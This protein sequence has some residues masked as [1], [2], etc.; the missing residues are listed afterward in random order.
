MELTQAGKPAALTAQEFKVLR[1]FIQNQD[2][3][4]S[5]EELLNEVWGIRVILQ[6]G[7]LIIIFSGCGKSLRR[8]RRVLSTSRPCTVRATSLYARCKSP[9]ARF[10][11]SRGSM[12]TKVPL[13]VKFLVL[14]LAGVLAV[15][16]ATILVVRQRVE[17]QVRAEISGDLRIP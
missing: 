17:S 9:V 3:V 10:R 12:M 5:R 16:I 4:I 14:L 1:F 13:R 2:R 15:T 7:P 6:R 11:G 8:T